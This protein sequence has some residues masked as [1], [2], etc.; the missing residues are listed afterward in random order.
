MRGE[1]AELGVIGSMMV[2]KE[3]YRGALSKLPLQQ[4]LDIRDYAASPLSAIQGITLLQKTS[5]HIRN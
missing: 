2:T 3:E 5:K 1:H 4:T